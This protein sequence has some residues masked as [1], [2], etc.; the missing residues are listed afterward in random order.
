MGCIQI[1]YD[2]LNGDVSAP[3][4]L[5]TSYKQAESIIEE[6]LNYKNDDN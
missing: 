2:I 5:E 6:L 4:D 1:S 3:K